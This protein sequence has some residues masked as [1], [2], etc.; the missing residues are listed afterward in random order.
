MLKLSSC[1]CK[2]LA[3]IS[4][5][6]IVGLNCKAKGRKIEMR[7]F[8]QCRIPVLKKVDRFLTAKFHTCI[9]VFYSWLGSDSDCFIFTSRRE[10]K[11]HAR[12]WDFALWREKLHSIDVFAPS[13][14][15]HRGHGWKYKVDM[16]DT[17][18]SK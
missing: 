4:A 3:Q 9:W 18:Q 7:F 14:K 17:K 13:Q 6:V 15:L 10:L 5:N 2:F 16:T 11:K 12:L 8:C 1:T